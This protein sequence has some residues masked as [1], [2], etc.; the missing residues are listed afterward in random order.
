MDVHG[1]DI[2]RISCA[3]IWMPEST[4]AV[5]SSVQAAR[6]ATEMRAAVNLNVSVLDTTLRPQ[7]AL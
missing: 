7:S 2:R 4:Q 1:P 6:A 3:C 5:S